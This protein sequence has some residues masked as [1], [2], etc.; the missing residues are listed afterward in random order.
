MFSIRDLVGDLRA[1]G[2]QPGAT[3]IVH[4]SFKSIGGVQGGPAAVVEA[5][6][7]AVGPGGLLAMPTFTF[8]RDAVFSVA[9]SPSQTGAITE[10]FRLSEGAWR[11]SHP[12]HASAFWGRDAEAL[13]ASRSALGGGLDPDSSYGLAAGRPGARLLLV[14]IDSRR[15]SYVH[16]CEARLNLPYVEETY[17]HGQKHSY[18]IEHLDGR[19]ERSDNPRVPGCAKNFDVVDRRLEAHGQLR[20]VRLGR[21]ECLWLNPEDVY[22]AVR[23]LVSERADALLCGNP[24]CGFCPLARRSLRKHGMI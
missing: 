9:A 21:A 24:L 17:W 7:L 13:A 11:C 6:K 12:T 8:G 20:R 1:M 10:F 2:V 4:S 5:L 23:A 16:V 22:E 15:N 19:Q 3:L 14:G 18:V